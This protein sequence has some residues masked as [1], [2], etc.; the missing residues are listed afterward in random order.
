MADDPTTAPP[1]DPP[2]DPAAPPPDPPA[3]PPA[4]GEDALPEGAKKALAAARKDAREAQKT[5][6]ELAAQVK[7]FEDRD[8]SEAD[9]ASDRATAAEQRAAALLTR[10]VRAEVR[11]LAAETFADPAD[12]AAFLDMAQYADDAGEVDAEK[13]KTDLAELLTRKPHL[14]K[15]PGRTGPKPDP[16]QG[17]KPPVGLEDQIRAAEKGGRWREVIALERQKLPTA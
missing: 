3:D 1:A 13:I 15:T 12:A 14:A 6:R 16:S 7:Q 17:P 11:A 5:A 2:T 9:K 8:K 10:A 4:T